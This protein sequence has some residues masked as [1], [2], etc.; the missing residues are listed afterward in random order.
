MTFP[1]IYRM[2][3]VEVENRHEFCRKF[4]DYAEIT[5]HG[6]YEVMTEYIRQLEA[7]I[8]QSRAVTEDEHNPFISE[9]DYNEF[10]ETIG[11]DIY[12]LLLDGTLN[13]ILLV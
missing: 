10:K 6:T 13:I 7:D 1:V 9:A 12:E 4:E 5:D 2:A 3:Y 11:T 8:E